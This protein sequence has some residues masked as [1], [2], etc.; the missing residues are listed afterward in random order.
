M[1]ALEVDVELLKNTP[2]RNEGLIKGI[3]SDFSVKSSIHQDDHIFNFLINHAGFDSDESRIRYYFRDGQTSAMKLMGM[4]TRHLGGGP[5]SLFEFASGY[6]CVTR[7]LVKEKD[8]NLVS[9]DIHP[10]A[11]SFLAH[12]LKVK[13]LQSRSIPEEVHPGRLYDAVFALSFFSHMPITTWSRWLVRLFSF[14]RPGGIFIFTTHGPRSLPFLGMEAPSSEFGFRFALRSE[15]ADLP[16]E[17][18]G[19]M[20]MDKEFVVKHINTLGNAELLDDEVDSW[21]NH[22][23]VFVVRR[24]S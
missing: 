16:L 11:I 21:W 1:A 8:I 9:C 15:Q 5:F 24:L 2:T 20:A 18:Y 23:D 22:Q 12:E 17:E 19:L 14:V 6:G 3:A 4:L 7:H 10:Q 13:A